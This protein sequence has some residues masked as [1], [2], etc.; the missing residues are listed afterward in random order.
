MSLASSSAFGSS[1]K[2]YYDFD[3]SDD[4]DGNNRFVR[5][6]YTYSLLQECDNCR[7]AREKALRLDPIDSDSSSENSST[8][9]NEKSLCSC[10]FKREI[11]RSSSHVISASS[12]PE[13]GKL[14]HQKQ[15]S[16]SAVANFPSIRLIPQPKENSPTVPE[17]FSS[18]PVLEVSDQLKSSSSAAADDST[19]HLKSG[20]SANFIIMEEEE[21][22]HSL[23]SS[24]RPKTSPSIQPQASSSL[25]V[26][27]VVLPPSTRTAPANSV[28]SPSFG[29]KTSPT[30]VGV[31]D[32]IRGVPI[33]ISAAAS[34]SAAATNS[35]QN[36]FF[37]GGI[38]VTQNRTLNAL[39]SHI[40]QII[41]SQF[42]PTTSTPPSGT[43]TPFSSSD[44]KNEPQTQKQSQQSMVMSTT[45]AG[46][47]LSG[48]EKSNASTTTT[49]QHVSPNS[50]LETAV[51]SKIATTSSTSVA[52][53]NGN[54]NSSTAN[55]NIVP[56][57]PVSVSNFAASKDDDSS[58]SPPHSSNK[59]SRPE[60]KDE[61]QNNETKSFSPNGKAT[62]YVCAPPP[63]ASGWDEDVEQQRID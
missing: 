33:S 22:S 25:P 2:G 19:L 51:I 54:N 34:S 26:T 3:Q 14:S 29:S 1:H 18:P 24:L 28:A 37:N 40:H 49:P 4:E 59:S 46:M 41:P 57:T 42:L 13:N 31:K 63:V 44:R 38:Y 32:H 21:P 58:T 48:S 62:V 8:R 60:C 53:V 39:T 23:F 45:P 36:P 12:S 55:S 30:A 11:R 20:S 27:G 6:R 7:H 61:K 35:N 15:K 17:I 47:K 5:G 16:E 43:S 52:A 50:L 56:A 10:T 9:S